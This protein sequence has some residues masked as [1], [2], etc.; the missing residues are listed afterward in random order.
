MLASA[1]APSFDR[2]EFD[3]PLRGSL[4]ERAEQAAQLFAQGIMLARL[5]EG[6][7]MRS[8]DM[9]AAMNSIGTHRPAGW[10]QFREELVNS[11]V[12]HESEFE[13]ERL[14]E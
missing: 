11:G 8:S 14:I 3:V 10:Q 5:D 12:C 6:G 1:I 2:A 4:A 9:S 13:V 7:A